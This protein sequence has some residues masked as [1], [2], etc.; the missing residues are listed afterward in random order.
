MTRKRPKRHSKD[1]HS[2]E[3]D[4]DGKPYVCNCPVSAP[5]PR[6]SPEWDELV[7]VR[8]TD[9]IQ[10][11]FHKTAEG[12]LNLIE[13]RERFKELAAKDGIDLSVYPPTPESW[14]Y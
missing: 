4:K 8:Q 14:Q 7:T 9:Y 10:T 11:M 1:C 2:R 12:I 13:R 6:L 3:Y 5:D